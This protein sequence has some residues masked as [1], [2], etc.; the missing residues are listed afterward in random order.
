MADQSDYMD[1]P[2]RAIGDPQFTPPAPEPVADQSEALARRILERDQCSWGE[3]EQ[4]ARAYLALLARG[5]RTP[6]FAEACPL[7]F[8]N[9]CYARPHSEPNVCEIKK[10]P[11]RTAQEKR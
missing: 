1:G 10:C 8:E 11:I 2:G 9:A 7:V 6:G 3:A 5:T 4:L